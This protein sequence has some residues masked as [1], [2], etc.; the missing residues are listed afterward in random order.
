LTRLLVLAVALQLLEAGAS[1]RLVETGGWS[2]DKGITSG[3]CY[4]DEGGK[5]YFSWQLLCNCGKP[6]IEKDLRN[7]EERLC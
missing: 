7:K 3:K 1:R 4:L 2:L 5:D 6:E